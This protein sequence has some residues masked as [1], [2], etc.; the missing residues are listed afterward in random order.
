MT[1]QWT[2]VPHRPW[3]VR[4]ESGKAIR[5]FETA[6]QAWAWMQKQREKLPEMA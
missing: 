6:D 2:A 1:L 4:D 5:R 3:V